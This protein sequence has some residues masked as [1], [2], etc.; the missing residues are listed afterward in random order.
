MVEESLGVNREVIKVICNTVSKFKHFTCIGYGISNEYYGGD[1]ESLTGTGQG[2]MLSGAVC[3][4]QSCLVF[5]KTRKNEKGS[6]ANFTNNIK[7]N[8]KNGDSVCRR[9]RFLY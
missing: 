9:R 1:F 4:D 5:K 8:K 6:R 2:N 7:K 3:R